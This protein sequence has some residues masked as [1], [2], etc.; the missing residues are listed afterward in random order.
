MRLTER[1]DINIGYSC[2]E[3][4]R[5]CYYLKSVKAKERD[6]DLSTEQAKK[7]IDYIWSRGI[8]ILDFTGGEPTIRKDFIELVIYAKER[9]FKSLSL[10][11]NGITLSNKDY[12][13]RVVDA[14]IDDFLF[15]LHGSTPIIHDNITGFKG[16]FDL[17]LKG[18][19]NIIEIK[20]SQPITYRS[21]TVVCGLNYDN[22][23]DSLSL[24]DSM[25]FE[26]VN[27]ILF[28]PIVEA[29]SSDAELNVKYSKAAPYLIDGIDKY[30]KKIK[31]ISVRYIPF[32]LMPKHEKYVT[33]MAQIQYDPDEWDYL[34][35]T[36]IREGRIISFAALCLGTIM[37]PKSKRLLQ[38]G[39]NQMKH[40]GIKKFLEFKNKVKGKVC[41]DC[42]YEHI[43]DGLWREYAKWAGFEE[44]RAVQGPKIYDPVHFLKEN[45]NVR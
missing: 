22:T 17:M 29:N 11:T 15:S 36:R 2:N 12:A 27:F 42:S 40:E 32:C 30:G 24:L 38:L 31:K 13:K 20:K 9:G 8:K 39:C 45:E 35:R 3:Q 21:N 16:S 14:G 25:G 1:V 44:L 33:N 34:V 10:I 4:C 43:C 18:I 41:K 37:L 19:N 7:V 6:K 26:T 28:N 5:F 23:L